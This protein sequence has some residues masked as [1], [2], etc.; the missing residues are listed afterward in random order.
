MTYPHLACLIHEQ[1]KKYGSRVVLRYRDD[2]RSQWIPVTWNQFSNTICV[3]AR[4]LLALKVGVQENI[5]IFSQ[6]KP[7]CLY[8]DFSAFMVRAVSVPLYATSS[9]R[10]VQEIINDAKLR[11]MFVG[12]QYQ[13]DAAFRAMRSCPTLKQLIIFSSNVTKHKDDRTSIYYNH[14]LNLACQQ[15]N[16][17]DE[18]DRR[19][20]SLSFD[21][22]ANILY[23]SGTT[24]IS[25]GVMLHH[26]CYEEAIR[27]HEV[28]LARLT[29]K[30]VVMSFLPLTHIFEK[31]WVYFCLFR[32]C[33]VCINLRPNDIQRSIREIHP[34]AMCAVPRYWEKVYAAVQEKIAASSIIARFFIHRALQTGRAYHLNYKR[35]GKKPPLF[36]RLRYWIYDQTIFSLLK[37]TIGIERG[38]FFPTAG[39][40]IPPVIEEFVH[41]VGINMLAGYGLTETTAT[42]SCD[43]LPYYTIGSVGKVI[44]GLEIK[45]DENNEILVR[46]KTVTKGYYNKEEITRQTIDEDG[47]FHTGDAGY[48]KDGE[49]FLTDR[50]KDLF[51]T[52]YGKYIAPQ[53]I[54]SCLVIDRYIDQIAVI[55]NQRKYVTALIVPEYHALKDYA[56]RHGID[57]TNTADLL[58][59]PEIMQLY[60]RR[61][62]KLQ[63]QLAHYEQIKYFTLLNQPFTMQRGELTNTLK[64]IRNVVYRH[65]AAEIEEMYKE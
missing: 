7:E 52:S 43:N 20:A 45:I 63:K 9:E 53:A 23:T 42:V 60:R 17:Q 25:K 35:L 4:A 46:G 62:D 33:E 59:K 61:I 40:T 57:Y 15:E 55:A 3:A 22:L 18:L 31:A 51:K 38:N 19:M 5:G 13:Y 27:A 41:S 12:E 39:A 30:D 37:K 47:W 50:I 16:T 8:S 58:Q 1:A 26:S 65:Y 49:L 11:I 29:E 34:T 28:R 10:Q 24:G 56:K 44:P 6:N 32:G 21:D 36:L 2:I 14:F 64:I 54:E 48:L